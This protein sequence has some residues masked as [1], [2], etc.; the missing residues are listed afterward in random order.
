[1]QQLF[2]QIAV[3]L[4]DSAE[5]CVDEALNKA[6]SEDKL[7]EWI[8]GWNRQEK[9]SGMDRK[10]IDFMFQTDV[11]PIFLQIKSSKRNAREFERE[12]PNDKIRT[13]VV[14]VLESPMII[15]E[16]VIDAVAK[17]RNKFLALRTAP[18]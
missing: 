16:Q 13:V 11:G 2:G 10:G 18:V 5:R 4:G 7:P 8:F 12:H 3:E 15:F 14:N 6:K 1:L 9:W 17:Q